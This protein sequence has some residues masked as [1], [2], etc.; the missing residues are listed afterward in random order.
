MRL[1]LAVCFVFVGTSVFAQTTI[2]RDSKGNRTGTFTQEGNRIIQRDKN[3]AV[4]GSSQ[5]EGSQIIF[6]DRSGNRV[7]S[8]TTQ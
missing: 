3:G 8:S 2:E 5:R 1:C 7:G 4:V 6:R